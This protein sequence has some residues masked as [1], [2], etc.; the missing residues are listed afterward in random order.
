MFGLILRQGIMWPRMAFS[1]DPELL[2]FPLPQ[3]LSA[4]ITVV[5]TTP[6]SCLSFLYPS[7]K[8]KISG[9]LSV[10]QWIES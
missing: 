4:E 1:S 9:T 6:G 5:H 7:S 10:A 8:I 2:I 3:I